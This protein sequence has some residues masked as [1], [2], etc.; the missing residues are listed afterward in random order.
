MAVKKSIES[1]QEDIIVQ[2]KKSGTNGLTKTALKLGK[3][4]SQKYLAFKALEK[5]KSVINLG[6]EKIARYFLPDI[7]PF[8]LACERI[9]AKAQDMT[10]YTRSE[11]AKGCSGK[12]SEYAEKALDWLIRDQK[13]IKFPRKRQKTFYF[14]HISAIQRVMPSV[15]GVQRQAPT[16]ERDL[17]IAAYQ[18][19]KER[20][21]FSNVE[22][23][24]LQKELGI[25]IETLKIFLR[26]ESRKGTAI[27][28]LGDWS[29][30]SEDIRAGAVYIDGD[31]RPHLLVRFK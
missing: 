21:R 19:V 8:E 25:D 24:E 4:S 2:I 16:L 29:L 14:I 20:V 12:L 6:T 11:L 23:S 5:Q 7:D 10:L 9:D 27:L 28:T 1:Y 3:P 30:S 17:V 13:L 31:N 18:R 15:Q 26:D 22:I